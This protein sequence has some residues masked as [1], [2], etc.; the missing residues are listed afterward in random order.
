M[1]TRLEALLDAITAST[2]YLNPESEEYQCRNPLAL[3]A[4]LPQQK[5][6]DSGLRIFDRFESGHKAALYDLQVKCGGDSRAKIETGSPL[7]HLIRCYSMPDA[8]VDSVVEFLRKALGEDVSADTPLHYFVERN[9]HA[10]H[11][12]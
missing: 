9:G 3:K 8:V 11:A 2:G 10:G 4:F 7:R 5:K 12:G 1:M 6:T